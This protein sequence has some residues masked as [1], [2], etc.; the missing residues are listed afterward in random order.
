MEVPQKLKIDL[1]YFPEI[2]LLGIYAKE[3]KSAHHGHTYMPVLTVAPF[4]IAKVWNP[5]QCP[6]TDE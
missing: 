4:T 1:P 3:M 2:P 6:L 5:S